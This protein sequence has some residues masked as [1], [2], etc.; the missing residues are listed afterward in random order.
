MREHFVLFNLFSVFLSSILNAIVADR[1]IS[2]WCS[3]FVTFLTGFT[4]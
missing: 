1:I 3:C 4:H 2:M